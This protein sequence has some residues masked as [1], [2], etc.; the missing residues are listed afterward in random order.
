MIIKGN[1]VGTPM[2]RTNYEQT[3]PT[4]ADYLK[5]KDVLDQ[6]I[7]GAKKAADDAQKTADDAQKTADAAQKKHIS[8]VATLTVSG[9]VDNTQTVEVDGVT[10]NNTLIVASAPENYEA[11]SKAGVYCSAQ[12]VGSMTFT[13]KSVPA[14]DLNANVMILT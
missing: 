4:K 2:P 12:A 11:Y 3:D 10:S 5:G 7:E 14:T 6:K 8:R 9:W 13:C 1:T